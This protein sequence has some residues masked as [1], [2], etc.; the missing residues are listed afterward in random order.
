MFTAKMYSEQGKNVIVGRGKMANLPAELNSHLRD[1]G[2][3]R[4]FL[5]GSVH[6]LYRFTEIMDG[7]HGIH[8]LLVLVGFILLLH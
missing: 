6:T 4:N 1:A 3:E 2:A 7:F 8:H 5:M